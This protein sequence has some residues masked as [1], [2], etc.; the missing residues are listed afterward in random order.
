MHVGLEASAQI[1][2]TGIDAIPEGVEFVIVGAV[3]YLLFDESPQPFDQIQVGR[4]GR[5]VKEFDAQY[6]VNLFMTGE[7][8]K[9]PFVVSLSNHEHKS[10]DKLRTNGVLNS[11]RQNK[12][13]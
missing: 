7:N 4:I 3:Q 1:G 6:S 5:Q 10:F 8:L 9:E 13:D 2:D 12:N 11:T